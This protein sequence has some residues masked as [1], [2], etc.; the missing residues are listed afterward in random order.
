[1]RVR[2]QD[3]PGIVSLLGG[4]RDAIRYKLAGA[5]GVRT[6]VGVLDLPLSHEGR[7]ALPSIPRFSLEGISVRSVGFDAVSLDL[8]LRV[9][10]PNAFALPL[11]A[12]DYALAIGGAQ[13]ARAQGTKLAAVAGGTSAVVAIP[14]RL[15]V[16]SAGRAAADLAKGGDVQVDLTGRAVVAGL[17]LPLELRG[18]VPARR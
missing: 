2:F 13:V 7:L 3:V 12:L 11:G 14:V 4:G 17:P 8:K 9:K 18:K 16:A 6:P 10:N 15:D 1:V 5:I